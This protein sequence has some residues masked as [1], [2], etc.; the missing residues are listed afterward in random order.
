MTGESQTILL[1]FT[2]DLAALAVLLGWTLPEEL[3][4]GELP[5]PAPVSTPGCYI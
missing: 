5:A 2:H 3:H 1:G 4:L